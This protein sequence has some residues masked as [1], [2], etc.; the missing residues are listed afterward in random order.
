MKKL[1]AMN[2]RMAIYSDNSVAERRL[3]SE[4]YIKK[5][6]EIRSAKGL[7]SFLQENPGGLTYLHK[8]LDRTHLFDPPL[9]ENLWFRFSDKNILKALNDNSYVDFLDNAT[10][11]LDGHITEDEAIAASLKL[12]KKNPLAG[13]IESDLY[14]SSVE[15]LL[16]RR[17][18]LSDLLKMAAAANGKCDPPL[19]CEPLVTD[20]GDVTLRI[21]YAAFLTMLPY[22]V[23]EKRESDVVDDFIDMEIDDYINDKGSDCFYWE[24]D[25]SE[26]TIVA[27]YP[28]FHDERDVAGKLTAWALT[29]WR[30]WYTT[31]NRIRFD[32]DRGFNI[33][34]AHTDDM[35][36]TIIEIVMNDRVG[37]CEVC[38]RPFVA[39][40]HK[41]DGSYYRK[42]CTNSCKTNKKQVNHD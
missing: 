8:M 7:V 42:Y 34:K 41:A 21:P 22:R 36:Q 27:T 14:E 26:K 11:A 24:N 23:D 18:R 30:S 13:E 38:G 9:Y 32:T 31:E 37:I 12:W 29:A 5:L 20:T 35:A 15:L 39:S 28:P 10:D 2:S 6:L 40:Q 1:L 4:D 16:W 17:D 3:N 25:P 19:Q 33:E